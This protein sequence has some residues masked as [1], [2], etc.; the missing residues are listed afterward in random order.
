MS[1]ERRDL[2]SAQPLVGPS[3]HVVLVPSSLLCSA[4][5]LFYSRESRVSDRVDDV[6]RGPCFFPREETGFDAARPSN[7]S[8][9]YT[10]HVDRMEIKS[11]IFLV[12]C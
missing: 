9:S 6:L 4:S 8:G 2:F 3:N 11:Y 7:L 5:P 1:R 12:V 10:S